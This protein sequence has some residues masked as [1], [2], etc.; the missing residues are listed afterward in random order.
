[1]HN[2]NIVE[3][4]QPTFDSFRPKLL[5]QPSTASVD[6]VSTKQ[7]PQHKQRPAISTTQTTPESSTATRAPAGEAV[8][9]ERGR[10]TVGFRA[11]W[12]KMSSGRGEGSHGRAAKVSGQSLGPRLGLSNGNSRHPYAA[13]HLR[14]QSWGNPLLN[15]YTIGHVTLPAIN[16]KEIIF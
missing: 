9:V 12:E 8:G 10:E 5:N 14:A 1:M 7:S 11:A 4:P 6:S 3:T 2:P 13:L 15:K 16:A